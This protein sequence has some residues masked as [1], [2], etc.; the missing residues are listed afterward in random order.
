MTEEAAREEITRRGLTL[1]VTERI[2][3]TQEAGT[4]LTQEPDEGTKLEYGGIVQ[5]VVSG[6]RGGA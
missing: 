6:A 1:L 2:I 3:H 5:V 4:I